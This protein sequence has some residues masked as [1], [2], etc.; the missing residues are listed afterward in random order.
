MFQIPKTEYGEGFHDIPG[1]S[2][3]VPHMH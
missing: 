3:A 1:F 2:H